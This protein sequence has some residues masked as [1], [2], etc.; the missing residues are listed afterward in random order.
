MS[1]LS[2]NCMMV[3]F[4]ATGVILPWRRTTLNPPSCSRR[5]TRSLFKCKWCQSEFMADLWRKVTHSILVN[6]ENTSDFRVQSSVRSLLNSSTL[7]QISVSHSNIQMRFKLYSQSLNLGGSLHLGRINPR[8]KSLPA[9]S[10]LFHRLL[11]KIDSQ[12]QIAYWTTRLLTFSAWLDIHHNAS[13]LRIKGSRDGLAP[14]ILNHKSQTYAEDMTTS[15]LDRF[16]ALI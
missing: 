7:Y 10:I 11:F 12:R 8:Q 3:L 6:W 5:D 15:T 2:V 14:V 4:R 9:R 16:L 13:S 1:G